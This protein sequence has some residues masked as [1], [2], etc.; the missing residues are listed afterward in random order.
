MISPFL[1]FTVYS[2]SSFF[3]LNVFSA[4]L[5]AMLKITWFVYR[6]VSFDNLQL[7]RFQWFI[8]KHYEFL[9]NI[10]SD[11]LTD[12]DSNQFLPWI[13]TLFLFIFLVNY[14]GLLPYVYA[15]SSQG[16]ITFS[17]SFGIW[18]AVVLLAIMNFQENFAAIFLPSGAPVF[19]APLLVIIEII[20]FGVRAISLGLRLCANITAGH[21]LLFIMGDFSWKIGVIFGIF[22]FL[23]LIFLTLLEIGVA[24]IQAFVFALLTTIYL[25]EALEFH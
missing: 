12:K 2:I 11:T 6:V 21:I 22:P 20:S 3:Y 9:K 17:F 13:Y 18:F 1:Q 7:S 24:F 23:I 19:L 10:I 15:I 5:L 16:I 8:L 14:L 25:S 4:T